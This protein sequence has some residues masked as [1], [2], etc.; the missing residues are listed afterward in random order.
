M[1]IKRLVL[2]IAL[3]LICLIAYPIILQ[4]EKSQETPDYLYIESDIY[5]GKRIFPPVELSHLNHAETYELECTE[6][7]HEYD[8]EGPVQKCSACHKYE[9]TDDVGVRMKDAMHANCRECHRELKQEDPDT[10]APYTCVSCHSMIEHFEYE[11]PDSQARVTFTHLSHHRDYKISCASCH[12]RYENGE[13]VWQ[14]GDKIQKCNTC[15]KA[16]T[17]HGVVK[18]KTAF[19][20]QCKSCH[21]TLVQGGTPAPIRCEECHQTRVTFKKGD[22]PTQGE[23]ESG[24][25][26]H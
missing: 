3:P 15:H 10:S 17:E 22:Q 9:E 26:E 1:N 23:E 24:E 13:N 18:L 25:S 5:K 7:H 11:D 2:V 21:Q 12:H 14:P 4:A 8:E 6:C 19:H 16:K 20:R